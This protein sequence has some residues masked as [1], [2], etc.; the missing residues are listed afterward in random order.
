MTMERDELGGTDSG[1][2]D[3]DAAFE[4][5]VA[6]LRLPRHRRVARAVG[7]VLLA[8][9]LLAVTWLMLAQMVAAQARG[10]ARPMG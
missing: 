2:F 6:P 7:S 4:A 8:A 10:L 1:A 3:W 5:I 9:A